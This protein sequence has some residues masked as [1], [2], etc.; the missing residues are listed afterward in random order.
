MSKKQLPELTV[1]NGIA[2]IFVLIIHG[3]G[4]CLNA[5]FGG[6]TYDQADLFL[7]LLTNFAAPAVPI[8]LFSSGYKFS[9]S[10]KNTP[11]LQFLKKRLPR[12]IVSFAIIN[13]FFWIIDAIVWM[14]SFDPLILMKTYISSWMG[15]TVAYQ[16]WYIPMYCCV[17]II[18][19]L[20]NRLIKNCWIRFALYV[21]VG[22]GQRYIS[23]YVPV[24]AEYPLIFVSY[25]VFFEMGY[26][27]CEKDIGSCFHI[28]RWG[29]C[30]YAV[31]TAV[32][33]VV[34]PKLSVSVGVKY[35]FY[36]LVGTVVFYY[37]AVL[38][39]DCRFLR[40]M[41]VMSYPIFLIHEPLIGRCVGAVLAK[42]SVINISW[43]YVCLWLIFDFVITVLIVYL[44]KRNKIGDVI[45][46]VGKQ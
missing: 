17:I 24:L 16:L 40:W 9:Y 15:N 21:L 36:Y 45:W 28:A 2:I 34:V 13:T 43:V 27:A 4:S 35:G 30:I 25:P 23:C 46:N 7:R 5:F 41:G 1:L 11:Y 6:S 33:S 20:I 8:F 39:K 42:I 37:L 26:I 10:D 29:I 12:V 32:L 31:I 18:C 14:E 38:L 3:A 44:L 22:I 19:P